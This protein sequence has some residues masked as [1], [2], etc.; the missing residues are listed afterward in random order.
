MAIP[1]FQQPLFI[2]PA[3]TPS[4]VTEARDEYVV[5]MRQFEQQV[6]PPPMSATTLWG[7]GNPDDPGSFSSPGPTIETRSERPVRVTWRNELV[8][9]DG[10]F[11]RHLLPVD[12]TLH[13]ADPENTGA[14]DHGG[15]NAEL[16]KPYVGPVPTIVHVHGAHSFDHS[17]GHPEAWFLPDATNIPETASRFGP[18]YR[19]QAEIGR[20]AAVFDYPQDEDAAT[21]WY[22]DHSLGM[23]RVNIYAGLAGY[24]LI[25][26]AIE[27][28]LGLPGPAPKVGDAPGTPYFEIPLVI[29]DRAFM[30][31]GSLSYPSS[32]A[33]YDQYPGPVF[34]DSDVPPIWGPEFIGDTMIV[35]GRAWPYLEVEPRLYRF[36]ILNASDARTLMLELDR[37]GLPF[38]K[39]GVDGGRMSRAP[40]METQLLMGP[41]ERVDVLVD[42]SGLA[43]GETV[44][45]K[46]VGPDDPWGGPDADPPQD[47]A[48]PDTTGQVMQFRVVAA[49]GAGIAG[50]VPEKFAPL[51]ELR[52]TAP[53]R[54]LLLEEMETPDGQF[55]VHVQLGTLAMG[56]LP[57]AAPP[58]EIVKVG[59]T[60]VWRVTNVTDDAHPIHIH[61]IDFQILDRQP[62]DKDRFKDAEDAWVAGTGPAPNLEDFVTGPPMKIEATEDGPKDTVIM[63]P[64]TITRLVATFDRAGTY[65]WHCHIIEHEDNDMMRPLV[66]EP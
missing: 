21:L 25:R 44:V 8:D 50:T 41:A 47:P 27:D 59:A 43:V 2:P 66:I 54:D 39:I 9:S 10:R 19:T 48:N 28:A 36:R 64:G 40:V 57:W 12:Q 53:T 35:N 61:L 20:G 4:A 37:A 11:L 30:D 24:W 26:D 34:P 22:H 55:P 65:V 62:I 52:P 38:V 56:P 5:A 31:D 49:T 33:Q 1:K 6:L 13:W 17:D 58:T 51:P 18:T 15:S 46:N 14:H 63:L 45:L 32:R 60:E 23:T 16:A 42:F 3:M 29:Q 7:Y